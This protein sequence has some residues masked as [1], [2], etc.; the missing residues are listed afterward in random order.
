VQKMNGFRV[1]SV[2]FFFCIYI[3]KYFFLCCSKNY[4]LT[5][6]Y[7]ILHSKRHFVQVPAFSSVIDILHSVGI[8]DMLGEWN[9]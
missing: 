4:V 1:I 2:V 3:G 5:N 8:S 6:S 7:L 9:T